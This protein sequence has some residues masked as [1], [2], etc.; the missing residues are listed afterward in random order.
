NKVESQPG[1]GTKTMGFECFEA[2]TP[3]YVTY[4]IYSGDPEVEFCGDPQYV[5]DNCST[6]C[7]FIPDDPLPPGEPVEPGDNPGNG[8]GEGGGQDNP[9]PEPAEPDPCKQAKELGKN[10]GFKDKMNDLKNNI[11]VNYER[12]YGITKNNDGSFNYQYVEGQPNAQSID[13]NVNGQIDGF[14]HSHYNGLL[15]IFSG[16]DLQSL[17]TMKNSNTM[18]D[19]DK[20]IYGVVTGDGTTY[21]LSIEDPVKFQAFGNSWLSDDFSFGLFESSYNNTYQIQPGNNVSTNETNFILLLKQMNTGLTLLKG[22]P[23]NFDDWEK[24]NADANNQIQTSNCN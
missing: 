10:Q 16:S 17:Y 13:I 12:G 18:T 6:V 8:G 22:D 1:S 24:K 2:C 23:A 19:V 7:V 5:G 11:N 20:F 21:L 9:E 15:S 3:M 14:I 4:C